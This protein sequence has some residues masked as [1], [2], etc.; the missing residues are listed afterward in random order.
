MSRRNNG[1]LHLII[2]PMFS[3]K[4]SELIR[5]KNRATVAKKNCLVIKY[6]KDDRYDND[7][8]A[9]HDD[10]KSDA[11]RSLG[12]DLLDT[13][14]NI[15]DLNRYDNIFIDEIQ[16][17]TDGADV[18][19][20]LADQGFEVVVCGLQG[21]FKRQPF[22]CIPNLVSY[23]DKITHLTAI[24]AENGEDAPFTARVSSE[25]EE[26]VIGGTDKYIAVSRKNH[27]RYN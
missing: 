14:K 2:G 24:D 18:C 15:H 1:S 3:G 22:G 27:K 9:T 16:F 6:N 7:K 21:N 25:T 13:I 20:Q 8:L 26:E 10:I 11:I 19:D 17:Y 4:T 5:L 12:N 23:A